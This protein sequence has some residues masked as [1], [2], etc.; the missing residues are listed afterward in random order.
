MR[1]YTPRT[2]VTRLL[3]YFFD[4]KTPVFI[5]NFSCAISRFSAV[6]CLMLKALKINKHIFSRNEYLPYA[7]SLPY[8]LFYG[9]NVMIINS[10]LPSITTI[11]TR[12]IFCF[13][14]WKK[15]TITLFLFSF[16]IMLLIAASFLPAL[17]SIRDKHAEFVGLIYRRL[18]F[19]VF[20]PIFYLLTS[21]VNYIHVNLYMC[22]TQSVWMNIHS[23][24]FMNLQ[25]KRARIG[26]WRVYS[27]N[28]LL[29]TTAK[30]NFPTYI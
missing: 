24:N 8:S 17:N 3:N 10:F 14:Y 30:Q 23:C 25:R 22:C 19:N 7:L 1:D 11:V 16:K 2:V 18:S 6:C 27:I 20:L 9:L 28:E 29:K 21:E 26:K 15:R 4:S 5:R 13:A 12:L